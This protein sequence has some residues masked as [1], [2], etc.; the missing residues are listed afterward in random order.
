[1]T[2]YIYWQKKLNPYVGVQYVQSVSVI[3]ITL[4]H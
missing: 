1:M 3:V 4:D 2:V